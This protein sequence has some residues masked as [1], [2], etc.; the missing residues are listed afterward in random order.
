MLSVIKVGGKLVDDPSSLAT[1]ARG[2]MAVEGRVVLVHGGGPEITLWQERLGI[3]VEWKDGLRVTS[4][5]GMQVTAMVL[6]GWMNKRLVSSI[7]TERGRAIGISG[8]DGIM[9]ALRK[10]GG[11]L[12][13]VGEVAAVDIRPL[14]ALLESGMIPVVSPVS[15]GPEGGP[16]NVNGDEA[17]IALASALGADRLLL[18]SDVPG[19]LVEGSVM[20]EIDAERAAELTA[21]GAIHGGMQVKVEMAL[22]AARLG[23]EVRI[24]DG[25]LLTEPG[26]G[27]C[28]HHVRLASLVGG[29]VLGARA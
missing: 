19:V 9:E 26:G 4:R 24:G 17:A 14:A 2:V 27:T 29:P 28:V 10:K 20:S 25:T 18:L 5:A 13:E 8:E 11:A 23:M 21:S 1:L 12:G 15:R 7:L 3:P 6:S 22:N 16:L